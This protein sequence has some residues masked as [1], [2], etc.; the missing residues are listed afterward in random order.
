MRIFHNFQRFYY[1]NCSEKNTNE[2]FDPVQVFRSNFW[3]SIGLLSINSRELSVICRYFGFNSGTI[4]KN[5]KENNLLYQF[6]LWDI[7]CHEN[8]ISIDDCNFRI[9]NITEYISL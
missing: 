9:I 4:I 5:N 2:L 1:K 3:L 6:Y 8:S 7:D